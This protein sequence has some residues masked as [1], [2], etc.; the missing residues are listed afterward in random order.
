H[1]VWLIPLLDLSLFLVVGAVVSVFVVCARRLGRRPGLPERG[2]SGPSGTARRRSWVATRLLAALTLLPPVWAAFPRISGGAGVLLALGIGAR[3]VPALERHA[4]GFRRLVRVSFPV[5]A[6]L[7]LL[8]AASGWSGDRLEAW[9]QARR[10]L[11]TPGSP[12]V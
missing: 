4:A 10:P 9:R 1:F 2:P 8:L 5:V 12:N 7:V 6:G 11:P 3:M